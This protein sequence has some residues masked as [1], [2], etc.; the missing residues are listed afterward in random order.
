MIQKLFIKPLKHEMG[1]FRKT[2]HLSVS[3]SEQEGESRL[4]VLQIILI[5]NNTQM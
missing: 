3:S 1:P 5:H 2:W 4:A